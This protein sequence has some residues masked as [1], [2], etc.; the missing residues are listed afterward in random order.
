MKKRTNLI[1][2][3]DNLTR[4]GAETMLIGILRELNEE[5]NVVLVTLNNKSDFSKDEIVCNKFYCLN[6][7][8]RL[9]Y[10]NKIGRLRKIISEN[11]PELI[12]T[13]LFYST[14]LGRLARQK[15]IP[16]IFTVHNQISRNT[17]NLE[18]T[19][20]KL[21]LKKDH[22]LIS[23][24]K[25]VEK[26]YT[27]LFTKPIQKYILHNYISDDFFSDYKY[28]GWKTRVFRL[29]AVGNI[30]EAKN[31]QYLIQA[32]KESSE[33][34]LSIDIFGATDH[35][36]YNYL[37]R[38]IR[39][40]KLP[41][42]FLGTSTNITSK[43]KEYDAFVSCSSN[44]GFGITVIEAMASGLPVLLSDIP[45][46]REITENN[47]LFFDLN[48]PHSFIDLVK[49]ILENKIDLLVMSENGKKH[50][51]KFRKKEYILNLLKIYQKVISINKNQE[52]E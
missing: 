47:A 25:S 37:E 20:E 31:Y 21:T 12:H 35:A 2:I 7:N 24:S 44:E 19:L 13:H 11:K 8:N 5:Y 52:K 15:K 39:A 6:A 18:H 1:I 50:A 32:L 48:S 42:R 36:L 23:V 29:V 41:I 45:V 46:F 33:L 43:L 3:I 4:G 49:N 14:I 28:V 30:K 10:F 27:S 34:S 9:H 38:E 26:D 17:G 51:E 40:Y 16:L 22:I